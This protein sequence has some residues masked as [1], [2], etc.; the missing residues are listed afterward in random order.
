MTITYLPIVELDG[1]KLEKKYFGDDR[2]ELKLFSHPTDRSL[3]RLSIF[4]IVITVNAA[5]LLK[6]I[7]SVVQ[8]ASAAS[9]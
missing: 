8:L 2:T 3:V 7:Q 4:G 6:A 5:S 9:R 1:K